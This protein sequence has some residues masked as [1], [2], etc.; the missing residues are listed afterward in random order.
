MDKRQRAVL[1]RDRLREAM[2][3]AGFGRR[4]LAEAAGADRST[5]AQLLGADDPRLP[6]S[7]LCAELAFHLRVS[8]DWLLGLTNRSEPAAAILATSLEITGAPRSPMDRNLSAWF[9]EAR[10]FKIRTVPS[11]LPLAVMT[12]EVLRFEYEDEVLRTRDQAIGQSRDE[13]AYS[14]QP[15][16][17]IELCLPAQTLE[18]FAHG[19]GVWR[20][21][22]LEARR[23]QLERM[24]RLMGELYPT[25]RLYLFDQR[26]RF[27]V[28]F[29]VF[30]QMRAVIYIG[31]G[32]F[33]FN[34]TDHIRALTRQF[35]D[36]VRDAVVQAHDVADHA[37]RLLDDISR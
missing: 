30:G 20:G 29:I 4:A 28:P 2:T 19:Q 13:L 3:R 6:N 36:L 1:F 10:G 25:M 22:G 31:Q 21:L 23:A 37:A 15:E 8:A 24:S 33:V 18:A 35:D 7:Q 11:S 26:R 16:T 34:S 5:I 27:S 9:D 12:E 32:Y 14:R 17:D